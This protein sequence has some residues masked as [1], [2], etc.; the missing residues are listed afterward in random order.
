MK[1]GIFYPDLGDEKTL[2]DNIS[3]R[4]CY[5]KQGQPAILCKNHSVA[6]LAQRLKGASARKLR[7]ELKHAIETKLWGGAFWSS[8]Y[9]YRSVGST[10]NEAINWY[11]EHAQRKHWKALD[12]QTYK[13]LKQKTLNDYV[14]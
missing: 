12:H 2:T 4:I 5:Q 14:N 11:I 9:F 10:T 7:R 1:V 8:G 3:R 13:E 6:Q